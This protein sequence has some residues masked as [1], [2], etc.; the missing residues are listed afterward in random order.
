MHL[1]LASVAERICKMDLKET[2]N[3][4]IVADALEA[5]L[6]VHAMRQNLNWV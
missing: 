4:I 3:A 6:K 1:E 5:Q 2:A